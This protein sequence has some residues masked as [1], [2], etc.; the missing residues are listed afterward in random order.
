MLVLR[1]RGFTK[2]E[3]WDQCRSMNP[4]ITIEEFDELW[5]WYEVR[6]LEQLWRL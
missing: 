2:E 5:K 3:W 1:I 6:L 4:Y